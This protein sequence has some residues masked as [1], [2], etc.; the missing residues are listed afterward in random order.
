MSE[1]SIDDIIEIA[2]QQE[3][4]A[5]GGNKQCFLIDT[6]A[7][8]RQKFTTEEID[9][10]MQIGEELESKGVRVARTLDYKILSQNTQRWNEYKKVLVSEGYVLQRRAIG[11]PLL[12]RTN[13]DEEGKKYQLDYLKQ[14][15][16]ISQEGQE[17]FSNFVKGWIEIQK[18]CIRID[19]SKTGN[20]IYEQGKDITFIDLGLSSQKTD[21]P[22]TIY[23]QLAVILNLNAYNKCYPEIQQAVDKRLSVIIDKYRNAIIEQ[24]IDIDVLDQV[25]ETK[26]IPQRIPE[27]SEQKKETPEDEMVRLE[28]TINEHVRSEE[29]A[30]QEA[31][32]LRAEQEEKA[33]IEREKRKAEEKRL[34][35]AEERQNGGK[36]NDSK[37]YA[38]LYGL[39]K[40]GIFPEKQAKLFNQV[41]KTKKNMYADLNSQ[42]FK[43][44]DTTVD[45]DSVISNIENSNITIDM[46]SME[47]KDNG[48][49]PS[50]T[51][52]QIRKAVEDYFKHYFEEISQD[53]ET[54]MIE[55][56]K[57]REMYESGQL[58]EE[59][60]IDFGLLK[61][62][63]NEFSNARQFFSVLALDEQVL[64]NADRVSS[65]LEDKNKIIEEEKAKNE[66]KKRKIDRDYLGAVFKD[67]GITDPEE[68]RRLY[69]EQDK[70]RVAEKDLEVV[71]RSFYD[72]D[73]LSPTQIG[74]ATARAGTGIADIKGTTKEII[75]TIEKY[76][77]KSYKL[78]SL[79]NFI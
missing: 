31:R 27:E 61:A 17:F 28:N 74:K 64:E 22:T 4:N 20:F 78:K 62:E 34:D 11:K 66:S 45:L 12:D 24:G 51:Y 30:R 49:I 39:L 63:L 14:I 29:I 56:S 53:A 59:Q 69:Y 5:H 73:I 33:R 75:K 6:Y 18:A 43:K 38:I 13:W 23:E 32:R 76:S 79:D 10:I 1:R 67:T 9:R 68:L 55:Y 71:L 2:E 7:L 35:E 60:H 26:S 48:N 70:I 77:D 21:I 19:P 46:K 41:F 58:T 47:L 40:K 15:N 37:M 16:S 8:L 42:L 65:F 57:M 36:R 50:Q 25:L 72:S 52:E 3:S 44:Q 54:K